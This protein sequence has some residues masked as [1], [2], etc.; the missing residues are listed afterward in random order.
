M[1]KYV[2]AWSDGS[3]GNSHSSVFGALDLQ[4]R[5]NHEKHWFGEEQE[6][7]KVRKA[8]S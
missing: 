7:E 2:P 8:H 4:S 5:L 1:R 6:E 3:R